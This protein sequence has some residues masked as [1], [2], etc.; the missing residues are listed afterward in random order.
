MILAS[1]SHLFES[2]T[3]LFEV[4]TNLIRV[5]FNRPLKHLRHGHI[6]LLV[7]IHHQQQPQVPECPPG[8]PAC[9]VVEEVE[10]V[11]APGDE[12][13]EQGQT[14]KMCRGEELQP[15]AHPQ[16]CVEADPGIHG[17][18]HQADDQLLT[19]AHLVVCLTVVEWPVRAIIG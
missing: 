15:P 16:H 5:S 10:G 18:G 2:P 9:C 13:G 17:A 11:V 1:K 12:V 4:Q 6:Q 19:D 8:I 14:C 7:H 3:L